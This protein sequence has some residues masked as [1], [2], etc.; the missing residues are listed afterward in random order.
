MD[1]DRQIPE[2]IRQNNVYNIQNRPDT[3]QECIF[4]MPEDKKKKVFFYTVMKPYGKHKNLFS[5]ILPNFRTSYIRQ[6]QKSAE[7]LK[8]ELCSADIDT[9][10]RNMTQDLRWCT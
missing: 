9:K 3:V 6:P 8:L 2:K 7:M 4:I 5:L 10:N 1:L